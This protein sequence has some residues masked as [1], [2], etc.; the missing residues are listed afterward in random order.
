MK[1]KI[2]GLV[3]VGFAAAILSANAMATDENVVTSK[4]FTEATYHKKANANYQVSKSDGT[5]QALGTTLDSNAAGYQP[6]NAVTAQT[7]KAYVDGAAAASNFVEN[8]INAAHTTIAPSG[9]AVASGLAKG[10]TTIF[11]PHQFPKKRSH[12]IL[13]SFYLSQCIIC[14]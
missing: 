10:Q 13:S 7:I 1:V 5:W 12:A 11:A 6:E 2:K 14:N 8:E 4:S 9:Q 3:F